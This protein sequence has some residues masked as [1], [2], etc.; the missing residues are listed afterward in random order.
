MTV[1]HYELNTSDPAKA[2]KFYKSIFGWKFQDMPMPHG[3]YT[4]VSSKDGPIGGIQK[5]PMKGPSHWLGY[6]TVASVDRTT[7]KVKKA[8]G[9]VLVPKI[10]VPGMGEY[11]VYADPTGGTIGVWAAA[12]TKTTK[13]SKKKSTKKSGK[14]TTKKRSTKKST[15]KRSTKKT[16]KK[17]TKKR[18]TKKTAKK[19]STK[20]SPKRTT[21]KRSTKKS[22]KKRSTK[23]RR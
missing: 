2:K 18:S 8:G 23:K 5:N 17:T 22:S 3:T 14:K 12:K 20:K 10:V 16:A 1:A 15:K 19:R 21:K 7:A 11:A 4:M 6:M 9:K 13:N